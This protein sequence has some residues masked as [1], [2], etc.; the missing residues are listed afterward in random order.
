MC[1]RR[2]AFHTLHGFL[3]GNQ[4]YKLTLTKNH[5]EPPTDRSS[6]SY[7]VNAP[8][9]CP[10]TRW[11][12]T[13]SRCRLVRRSIGSSVPT[14][15]L[16][17]GSRYRLTSLRS[18]KCRDIR[19]TLIPAR[20]ANSRTVCPSLCA[21]SKNAVTYCMGI[22]GLSLK[23]GLSAASKFDSAALSS[24]DMLITCPRSFPTE[25]TPTHTAIFSQ[26]ELISQGIGNPLQILVIAPIPNGLREIASTKIPTRV[27]TNSFRSSRRIRRDHERAAERRMSCKN[28]RPMSAIE[29]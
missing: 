14:T 3:H 21:T 8:N 25:G 10:T 1:P 7:L 28:R 23:K 18:A 9:I 6:L 12:L 29:V 13:V 20:F 15:R 26:P 11:P 27:G 2:V 17:P 24:S 22:V 16:K 5:N 19:D 4:H